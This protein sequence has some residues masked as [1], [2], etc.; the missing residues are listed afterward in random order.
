MGDPS[1]GGF[2]YV[3]R[4]RLTHTIAP[5]QFIDTA[6][7]PAGPLQEVCGPY[8]WSAAA[9]VST[10][11]SSSSNL[12]PLDGLPP[13]LTSTGVKGGTHA[14]LDR[15]GLLLEESGVDRW[16]LLSAVA[17]PALYQGVTSDRVSVVIHF[18]SVLSL[19]YAYSVRITLVTRLALIHHKPVLY[20]LSLCLY[21][22][23]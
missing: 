14:R 11:I 6:V 17:I 23:M 4:S 20:T 10:H 16:D 12:I 8:G 3:H 2:A 19:H 15:P 7:F 18:G 21:V 1:I 13:I 22:Y 5:G 9:L